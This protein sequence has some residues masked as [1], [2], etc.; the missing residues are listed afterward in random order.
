MSKVEPS[1]K[2]WDRCV[3]VSKIA[4]YMSR[5][6]MCGRY[7]GMPA[8]EATLEPISGPKPAQIPKPDPTPAP[9]DS[10]GGSDN[11]TSEGLC[12]DVCE[13]GGE[14]GYWMATRMSGRCVPRCMRENVAEEALTI[15]GYICGQ[16]CSEVDQVVERESIVANF[17]SEPHNVF[18]A[19]GAL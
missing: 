16:E 1:G 4:K 2:C 19:S 8:P 14:P 18:D 12:P 3:R 17:Q 5:G 15:R 7:C 11:A 13:T 9:T 6:Y 10:G